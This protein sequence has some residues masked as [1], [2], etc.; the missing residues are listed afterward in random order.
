MPYPVRR[1]I[2][3]DA[4]PSDVWTWLADPERELR[5]RSPQVVALE[6]LDEGPW[7]PGVRFRGTAEVLGREDTW[8]NR[9]TEVDEPRR[10]AWETVETT[11]PATAPGRYELEPVADGT[12]MTIHLEYT[13]RN[14]PGRILVP[15]VTRFVTPRVIDG[16]LRQLR[17]L[18]ESRDD[19]RAR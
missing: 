7:R 5:W 6:Q 3:I 15:L 16:F 1:S 13:P 4:S 18:A 17:D 2:D 19:V 8:V 11:A 10:L 9:L 14:L 12:R